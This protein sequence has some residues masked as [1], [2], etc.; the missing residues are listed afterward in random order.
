MTDLKPYRD[1]TIAAL[2]TLTSA[3]SRYAHSINDTHAMNLGQAAAN[4]AHAYA[5]FV[6]ADGEARRQISETLSRSLDAAREKA[7]QTLREEGLLDEKPL[8]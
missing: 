5:A 6:S 1:A 4:V 7:M 2:E 8:P 3:A